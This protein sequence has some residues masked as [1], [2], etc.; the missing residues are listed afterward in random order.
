VDPARAQEIERVFRAEHGRA[1]SVLARVFGDLDVA[2]DAVADA[3]V[4]AL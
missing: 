2:E 3:F 1:V 4:T